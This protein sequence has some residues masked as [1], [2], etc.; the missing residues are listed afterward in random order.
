MNFNIQVLRAFAALIVVLYHSVGIVIQYGF[1]YSNYEYLTFNIGK[2]G[3]FGVDIF[4][5]ISGFIMF[6]IQDKKNKN[7]L[8]FLMDRIKRIVPIYWFYTIIFAIAYFIFPGGFAK[9]QVNF[10]FLSSSLFFISKYLNHE[11]PVLYVGWTLELEMLFYLIFSVL[12]IRK[13]SII[14]HYIL[15]AITFILFV[16]LL[17]INSIIFEF[18]FGG[19][20]YLV[21][22]SFKIKPSNYFWIPAIISL[23][24]VANFDLGN[25]SDSLRFIYWGIPAL[26]LFFCI[27]N[28]KQIKNNLLVKLGDASYSIY[29]VQVFTLPVVAKCFTKVAPMTH[30]LIVLSIMFIFTTIVGYLSYI[31]LERKLTQVLNKV[32]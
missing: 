16:Y 15:M 12:L 30:G 7:S 29:L 25:N 10:D 23:I 21:L 31:L 5:I 22:K 2:W 11:Y 8:S 24:F 19:I 9:T 17:N 4:F 14:N 28:V 13:K 26:I 18:L 3:S 6:M 32:M 20:T 27:I 1:S